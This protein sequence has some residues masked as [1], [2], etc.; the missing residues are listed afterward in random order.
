M[1]VDS[2]FQLETEFDWRR[3]KLIVPAG[4]WHLKF[5]LIFIF[6]TVDSFF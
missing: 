1:T 2:F 3:F 5:I 6:M 4:R